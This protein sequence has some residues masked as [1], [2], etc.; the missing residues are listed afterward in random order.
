MLKYTLWVGILAMPF[1]NL[2]AFGTDQLNAQRIFCCGSPQ[3]ARKAMV[4]S[5]VSILITV[6]MLAVGAGLFAWY[7]IKG[8][9]ADEAAAFA[10]D[11]NK[12]FPVWITTVLPP[13]L[14]GLILAGAF[15]AAISSLD[16]V[17]A[18]LSQT[19]LSAIYGRGRME[20]DLH[21]KKMVARSRI[22]VVVWAG[23]LSW[24]AI[25]MAK[26][27]EGGENKNL[28]TLAFGM[29]AYTYPPL[30]GVLLAAILP[31]RK[32]VRGLFVGTA[33]SM[34]L[35]LWTRPELGQLLA[36]LQVEWAWLEGSRPRIASEWFFPLNALLTL[37][38]GYLGALFSGGGREGSKQSR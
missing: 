17:L 35:V 23:L 9:T 5:C 1:Q 28:I 13:G 26:G 2:A 20:D 3:E 27:H 7:G 22:A 21:G 12:V 18:A 10:S 15:A 29:V 34:L 25:A 16:S 33:L 37:S 6:V 24:F 32:S 31:G 30:L 19:S 11:P 4:W 36:W 14:T 38:C 8:L